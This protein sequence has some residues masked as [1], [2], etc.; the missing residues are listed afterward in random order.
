VLVDARNAIALILDNYTL[1]EMRAL[2]EP[3]QLA[4]LYDSEQIKAHRGFQRRFF[5]AKTAARDAR[6]RLGIGSSGAKI[7]DGVEAGDGR[8][9]NCRRRVA[10]FSRTP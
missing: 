2:K 10:D 6:R 9:R 1:A 5:A 7:R 4:D 3:L 8:V